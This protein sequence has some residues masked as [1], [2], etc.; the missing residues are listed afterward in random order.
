MHS[1][2]IAG[3][4]LG[5]T[6]TLAVIAEVHEDPFLR[7][8]L[9]IL[10]VGQAPSVGMR[11]VVTHIEDATKSVKAAME[12]AELMAG[13]EVNSVYAGIAGGHIK[14]FNSHGIVA[15]KDREIRQLDLEPQNG[16]PTTRQHGGIDG[17]AIYLVQCTHNS[18][19]PRCHIDIRLRARPGAQSEGERKDRRSPDHC[20]SSSPPPATNFTSS[21]IRLTAPCVSSMLSPG[22]K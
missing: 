5:T 15:G 3:V 10:G 6:K 4:D 8:D 1:I 18:A 14:G 11:Q 19:L 7:R 9:K 2:L 21:E 16:L 20:S 22:A 17:M 13:V 12:E